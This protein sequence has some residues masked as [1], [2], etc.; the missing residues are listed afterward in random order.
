MRKRMPTKVI[1]L[2]FLWA[3]L[4]TSISHKWQLWRGNFWIRA[5]CGH[6]L[7]LYQGGGGL[8]ILSVRQSNVNCLMFSSS[9]KLNLTMKAYGKEK[10]RKVELRNIWRWFVIFSYLHSACQEPLQWGVEF[11]LLCYLFH[12]PLSQHHRIPYT[13]FFLLEQAFDLSMIHLS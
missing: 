12:N 4:L 13:L 10:N 5:R 7:W 2:V 3:P 1:M 9:E 6:T 8:S 11:L